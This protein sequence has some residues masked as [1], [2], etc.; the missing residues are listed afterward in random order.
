MF[1]LFFKYPLEAFSKGQ[2]VL[3][4]RWPV[5]VLLALLLGGA[6][7]FAWPFLQSWTRERDFSARRLTIWLLQTATLAMLLLML[8]QPAL[9]VATLRPQQNIVAVVADD[10]RSMA[11]TDNGISRREQLQKTLTQIKDLDKKFQVRLYRAGAG[12]ERIESPQQLNAQ[13]P[14]TRLGDALKQVTSE[15]GSLP[16]GAVV[17]LS[18][19]ADNAGG[20]DLPTLSEIR[21]FRIPIH[22]VGYGR[23]KLDHDIEIVDAQLPTRVLADSRLGAQVTLKS[24][25]YANRHVRLSVQDGG[26]TIASKDV[27][28]KSDGKEQTES[29]IFSAGA[30]GIKTLQIGI[31]PQE[32]EE[33]RNNNAI[34]RLVSAESA[35]PRILYIEGEPKW[36]FKF[37][38]RAI[39]QDQSL[40]LTS[41]LRTTQNKI[42]RQGIET[43]A[44]LE[45]GFPVT[46]EELFQYQGIVIGGV[47]AN[48]FTP[49]QQELLK[50]F[51]DRR[52]GGLLWLGGRSGLADGGWERSALGDLLPV[53]LPD[54]KDT[55]HRDPAN[56]ELTA[57]GRDSLLCRLDDDPARNVDRWKKLPYL[58]NFQEAGV[59]KPGAVVLAELLPTSRGRHPLLVTQNYGRGRT[60]VFAT[61]GSWRWQMS[62]PLEDK[63]HEMFWQQM[64]RWLVAGTQGRVISSVPQTVFADEQRI[65]I[66]VEARDKSYLPL[67]DGHVEAT[68]MG[69]GNTN[70]KIQLRPDPATPGTYTADYAAVQPGSYVVETA[71]RRGDQEVGRDVFTF[72][73]EDGVAENFRTQQNRELLE[74]LASE[75]HGKYY[76]PEEAS[77]IPKEISYSEAGISIRETRDLWDMPIFF[78]GAILLRSS[79]WLLRRR[80]GLV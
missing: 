41:M 40:Q 79:E 51:V 11:A 47:E 69:P 72:R 6:A 25:G 46:V 35:R 20:I 50:Q 63:S 9:S 21:R 27:T 19:G 33:N 38:R 57:A 44:E 70:D 31:E 36:E 17:L 16:I 58:Q 76:R 54:R 30:A 39:E 55:F 28:L 22:T 29:V 61:A 34:T 8:W 23:E 65:P 37:I 4:G 15:A 80:W 45:Q 52:G 66:R 73:R 77:R 13:A 59:A 64:L 68:V 32:A 67:T 26:K 71:V 1:E 3:L 24:Y 49:T 53:N 18:D 62:Q 75:T 56:V 78:L 5:W 42:Y 60:A 43:P 74:K 10:S 12:A 14:S 48:Y 2:I 7:A